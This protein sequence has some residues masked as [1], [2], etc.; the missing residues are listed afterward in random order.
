MTLPPFAP[1]DISVVIPIFNEA[2]ILEAAVCELVRRYDARGWR[3]EIVL[4]ENGSSD[5]TQAIAAA[6][7]RAEPRLRVVSSSEPNYGKALR[8]GILAT[9]API[10]VCDEIDLCDVDFHARALAL[11][12][13]DE[14]DLI[15]GSKVMGGARDRRPVFRRVATLAYTALLRVAL[16]FPGTDTHGPKAFQRARVVPVV[17]RCVVDRDVFAS[18][19]VLRAHRKKLRVEELPIRVAEKRPPSIH[20]W[21][22]I[23]NVLKNLWRLRNALRSPG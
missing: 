4:A 18:E 11:L 9:R 23:P 14:A 8:E 1:P 6:L 16:G 12:V 17:E 13:A 20:L 21:R 22:R 19:L 15:V 10:V 5:G 2:A 3:Y 7:A